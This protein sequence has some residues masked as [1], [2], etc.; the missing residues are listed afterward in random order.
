MIGRTGYPGHPGRLGQ[1]GLLWHAAIEQAHPAA[2]TI[3]LLS[4][5]LM[6]LLVTIVGALGPG[7]SGAI[8]WA[9]CTPAIVMLFAWTMCFVPGA[10]G[11]NTPASAQ[12]APGMRARLFELTVLLWG[13]AMA[14]LTAGLLVLQDGPAPMLLLAM[15]MTL[16]VAAGMG[17]VQGGWIMVLPLLGAS[18][19][20]KL[21][22][23][24]LLDALR[25]PAA[26][27][28]VVATMIPCAVLVAR[29]LLPQAGD[30][31]WDMLAHRARA[32]GKGSNS[33]HSGGL[34]GYAWHGLTLGRDLAR[35]E[36]RALLMR[37][38]GPDIVAA[39]VASATIAGLTFAALT[40]FGRSVTTAG[41]T[42]ALAPSSSAMTALILLSFLFQAGSVPSLV[43]RSRS[44]QALLRLAP[45]MPAEAQRFN[46]LLA[47]GLLRQGLTIWI[48]VSATA[49]LMALVAGARGNALAA[50]ACMCCMTS[51]A[52]AL[53][54]RDHARAPAWS[55]VFYWL[56]AVGLSLIGPLAGAILFMLFDLPFW[57]SAT[58]AS[59]VVAGLLVHRR[60]RLMEGAPFAFPAGRLE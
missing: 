26:T 20:G 35:R 13:G 1:Y 32:L 22:P 4:M 15:A 60:L 10:T 55:A 42:E 44:E 46:R 57:A 16:G 43:A 17:G 31:H 23:P 37:A 27:A 36:P 56:F 38:L 47:H 28:M 41:V 21:A 54:L 3:L 8:G 9:L 6:T 12:L 52:I 48:F 59:I 2:H 49:V 5:G 53:A 18:L 19:A 34:A 7:M 39:T 29:A 33:F 58:I 24:W 45:A 25:T 40:Y 50:S 51:P 11:L 30:R 14:V